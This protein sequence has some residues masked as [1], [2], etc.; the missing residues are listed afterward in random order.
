MN[1]ELTKRHS[2]KI[3]AITQSHEL[4]ADLGLEKWLLS[5]WQRCITG[6]G[7]DPFVNKSMSVLEVSELKDHLDR[8]D[9][10]R[11][12]ADA[13][14]R[15]LY[16]SISGS[17][18][19]IMLTDAQGVI[20]HHICDPTIEK[21]FRKAGLR[22]GANW[23]ENHEGTNGIG[24]CIL[25]GVPVTVHRDEHF[26]RRHINLT[27]S[28]API[29]GPHGDLI[30]ILDASSCSS[31]DSRNSQIHLRA[32][33]ARSALLLENLNFLFEYRDEQVLR[34][35]HRAECIGLPN[36]A[37]LAL[38]HNR[39]ILA[40]NARAVEF[41]EAPSRHALV[42]KS[43]CE[44]FD[45]CGSRCLEPGAGRRWGG[46]LWPVCLRKTGQRFCALLYTVSNTISTTGA[47]KVEK[48]VKSSTL[49]LDM[50]ASSDSH[51]RES[52][53]A[54]TRI[55]DRRV[56]ILLR[57][58]TGTGKEVFA[59]AIHNA[60]QRADKS[61]VA[62]NCSS[63]PEALIESELFGYKHGA[64]T[65]AR[66]EGMKGKVLQSNGGTLFLD[67][68]GDMPLHLQT[69]LLRCL[70]ECEIVPLGANEPI[71]IDL[72]V[73]SATH[74]DLEKLIDEGSF[75]E[76]LYYRLNGISLMLPPL[77]EREDKVELIRFII[78]REQDLDVGDSDVGAAVDDAAMA[79]LLAYKWPGN[80]RELRNV[81][82][83]ALALC[84]ENT[85]RLND[86]PERI[87]T[88]RPD[89]PL[90][91]SEFANGDA[92]V[93][94]EVLPKNPLDIAEKEAITIA[95]KDHRWNVTSTAQAL[96]MSRNTLYRKLN[97]HGLPTTK[98]Q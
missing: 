8:L 87:V 98:P 83:T 51:M 82:R 86:L 66:R 35:H 41:L 4:P 11:Y 88:W 12:I 89:R 7:I 46:T 70:E 20:L 6:Y 63:I 10:L 37:L 96:N 90:N 54:A 61:F 32:L 1:S 30:A 23:S 19:A 18:F 39:R 58:E 71:A 55:M 69:R 2:Q 15:S 67:E 16:E 60:G 84:E 64:F 17:G 73:I 14:M 27:C 77:R 33:V 94:A 91:G 36:E 47:G 56:P 38:D 53:C 79:K 72:N 40:A 50:L 92:M 85:L 42:G 5:S 45:P 3:S 49:D 21:E 31:E 28:G 48:T 93:T 13:E 57:G 25:E 80:I 34:F 26:R 29:R 81:T 43:A 62:I 44:L 24:T 9:H 74:Q 68:I 76:D 95:L 65:G 59:R 75:R 52:V 78:E 97:K 22:L